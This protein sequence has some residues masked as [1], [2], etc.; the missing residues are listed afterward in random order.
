MSKKL[1]ALKA[2][3]EK[4]QSI[5]PMTEGKEKGELLALCTKE[6][7]VINEFDIIEF[8]NKPVVIFTVT[9]HPDNYFYGGSVVT[10]TLSQV[11]DIL[12]ID[13]DALEEFNYAG[14]PVSFDRQESKNDKT[15]KYTV[16]TLFP[17]SK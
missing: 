6:E 16:V 11:N 15:R 12:K 5:H 7:L 10:D 9:K 14:L 17:E 1:S 8:D 3:A 13:G 4:V 2:V